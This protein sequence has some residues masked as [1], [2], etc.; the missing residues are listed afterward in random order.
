MPSLGRP[1]RDECKRGHPR[2]DAN[3]YVDPKGVRHCRPCRR[4]RKK[5]YAQESPTFIAQKKKDRATHYARHR[6]RIRLEDRIKRYGITAEQLE[7]LRRDQDGCCAICSKPISGRDECIDHCH[8]SGI[9]RGL[10][11]S[12]C[13]VALGLLKDDVDLVK[14]AINYLEGAQCQ[15]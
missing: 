6:D 15:A 5:R 11:C 12:N 1:P 4:A 7:T 8:D 3:T 2:T 10:L 9:V 14:S 13:N